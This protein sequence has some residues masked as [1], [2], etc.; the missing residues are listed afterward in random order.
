MRETIVQHLETALEI[1]IE[2]AIV[3]PVEQHQRWLLLASISDDIATLA[4]S[5]EVLARQT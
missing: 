2:A 4:R 1:G 3:D 5:L